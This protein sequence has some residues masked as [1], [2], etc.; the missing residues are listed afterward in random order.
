M[1]AGG[2]P[3]PRGA[4]VSHN[5]RGASCRG[6]GAWMAL[7]VGLLLT[8]C[9][10][11]DLENQLQGH[12]SPYLALHGNDPVAWQDWGPEVLE[13]ARKTNR[14]ILISSGY[15][16]CHWCH[17]MQRE[18]F[19]DP[20]IAAE[21]NRHYIP[22]KL[23]RELEPATDA[24]LI[25]FVEQTRGQGGWPLNVFVTP[26]GYPLV[27]VLYLPPEQFIALLVRLRKE[28]EQG[29]AE[30]A[31][32][33]REAAPVL[34]TRTESPELASSESLLQGLETQA[35]ELADA[36]MGGFGQVNKFPMSPQL[37]ALLTVYA[38]QG[39]QPLGAFLELT[40]DNMAAGGLHDLL[41]GGFFRYTVDPAW[42]V[43]HFEKML[44][45]NAQLAR[46]YLRA[47]PLLDREEYEAVGKETLDLLL[48]RFQGPDGLF[49]ASLSAVDAEG[50]EGGHYLWRPEELAALLSAQESEAIGEHWRFVSNPEIDAIGRLPVQGLAVL[51]P[52]TAQELALAESARRKLLEAR[53]RRS[54]P[55]DDKRLAAWNGLTL[56]ALVA[57]ARLPQGERYGR[58]ARSLRQALEQHLWVDGALVRAVGPEGP[59]GTAGLEDYAYVA[60]GLLDL[61]LLTGSEADFVWAERLVRSAWARFWD[62]G[63]WYLTD[64]PLLPGMFGEPVFADDA[65]PAPSA[66]L[67]ETTLRLRELGRHTVSAETLD[68]ALSAGHGALLQEPFW[69]ASHATLLIEAAALTPGPAPA[70]LAGEYGAGPGEKRVQ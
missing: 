14:L 33:A 6:R 7:A 42:E 63:R 40:L 65:L 13:R 39:D 26:E 2:E 18:S 10:S 28:W 22:V 60:R 47:A 66:V 35:M 3:A 23:D 15:F 4:W 64:R 37:Q 16:A 57:G 51:P 5:G 1:R 58:A 70:P 61:A 67:L 36:T 48:R 9:S 24:Y 59:V 32:A 44:Y 25:D 8:A 29:A 11:E 12:A 54:L 68:I 38:E 34:R 27:G 50:L 49:I 69:Y 31:Q 46:L 19:Q 55:K 30:L 17:V 41:A 20:D 43:P 56:S 53:R 45:D 21:L 52:A 62:S